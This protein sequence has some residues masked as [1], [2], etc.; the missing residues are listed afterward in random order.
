MLLHQVA[1]GCARSVS[2]RTASSLCWRQGKVRSLACCR[3]I[4]LRATKPSIAILVAEA[5]PFDRHFLSAT[6]FDR[7]QSRR[8]ENVTCKWLANEGADA[9]RTA[10]GARAADVGEHPAS[11]CVP[12][13]CRFP[14]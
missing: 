12:L 1:Q 4:K 11:S 3:A 14:G 9:T 13:I 5:R 7:G 6:A 8:F 10:L 2:S